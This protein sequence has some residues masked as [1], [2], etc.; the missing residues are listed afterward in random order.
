MDTNQSK[1]LVMQAYEMYKNRNI[2]GIIGMLDDKVE[3]IGFDSDYIPFA[4]KHRGK[5]EVTQFFSKVEQAQDVIF[6]EPKEF[7]AEGEK[8]VVTGEASWRVKTTGQSYDSPWVHVF[9]LRNGK[10]LRFQQYNHTAAA[11][12][13]YRSGQAGGASPERPM[14]H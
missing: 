12:A 6:F 5:D 8:V 4:G 11:E 10:I 1:Q 7:I 3:W 9:T 2:K 14:R 13:A